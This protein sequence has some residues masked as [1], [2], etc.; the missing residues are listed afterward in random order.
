MLR[1]EFRASLRGK[2]AGLLMRPGI[3]RIRAV[4]DYERVGGSPLLGVKGTVIITHGRAKRRMI[5]FGVGVAA[6]MARTR[7]PELI[8]EALRPATD[9]GGSTADPASGIG[10]RGASA[11]PTDPATD[12]ATGPSSGSP[13][14]VESAS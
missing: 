14:A 2:V 6:T 7:V 13:A 5:G 4:F 9:D 11:S 12:D 8:A 1:R 3:A 10:A